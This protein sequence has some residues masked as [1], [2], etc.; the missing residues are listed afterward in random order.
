MIVSS[1]RR[2]G[3]HR[4]CQAGA[5]IEVSRWAHL[6]SLSSHTH[7]R[8]ESF[9]IFHPDGSLLYE[10]YYFNDPVRKRFEPPLVFDS[11]D[12]EQRSLRYCAVYNNGVNPDGTPNPETVTRASRLPESVNIQGVPGLCSPIACVAGQIGATC[13]GDEDHATCDSEP[14]AGDGVC[15]ACAITGGESTENEMFLI[16]G[17][18]YEPE[19]EP[20]E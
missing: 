2:V 8:G 10:N 20:S 12:E 7:Q 4:R 13:S 15:D 6:F 14:D 19:E 5:G 1:S 16:I 11:E 17:S 18:F 3:N 9:K